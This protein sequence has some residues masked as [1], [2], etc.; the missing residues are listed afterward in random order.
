MN[1]L[2]GSGSSLRTFLEPSSAHTG[3]FSA[4]ESSRAKEVPK[5]KVVED[6][7]RSTG[8][9]Q[10]KRPVSKSLIPN[11]DVQA[12]K[13]TVLQDPSRD[14]LDLSPSTS[15]QLR[16]S[17]NSENP[18][19]NSLPKEPSSKTTDDNVDKVTTGVDSQIQSRSPSA[20]P[21]PEVEVPGKVLEEVEPQS[22]HMSNKAK[23]GVVRTSIGHNMAASKKPL[24]R[25]LEN[26]R[27]TGAADQEEGSK[28]KEK[29]KRV[30]KESASDQV[31]KRTFEKRQL[32][33][34]GPPEEE[35]GSKHKRKDVAAISNDKE[36]KKK[37]KV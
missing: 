34:K 18:S 15:L 32:R 2:L 33:G 28:C 1:C 37:K 13:S 10:K 8:V 21:N 9:L 17:Q 12:T 23:S 7:G 19:E 30:P 29:E 3:N 36:Q 31:L 5:S 20:A 24:P 27:T 35:S 14:V 11:L 26:R 25:E 22:S 4:G 16:D 6:P